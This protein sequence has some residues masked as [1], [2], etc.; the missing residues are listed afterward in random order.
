[1]F[2]FAS[3]KFISVIIFLFLISI[4]FFIIK[5]NIYIKKQNKQRKKEEKYNAKN[6]NENF[7]KKIKNNILKINDSDFTLIIED[8]INKINIILKKTYNNNSY[9]KIYNSIIDYYMPTIN[10]MIDKYIEVS[11]EYM[12][13]SKKEKI[14]KDIKNSVCIINYGL[15]KMIEDFNIDSLIDIYSDIDVLRIILIKDGLITENDFPK[16]YF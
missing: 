9:K 11:Y 16:V 4:I 3:V 7:Y 5:N 8:M 12:E 13:E 15:K 6:P 2:W 1:M 10:K 14:K